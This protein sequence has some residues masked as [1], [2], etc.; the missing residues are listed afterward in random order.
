[1]TELIGTDWRPPVEVPGSLF[2]FYKN[3]DGM[4]FELDGEIFWRIRPIAELEKIA[5]MKS[6]ADPLVYA[7]STAFEQWTPEEQNALT[8]MS[9][10]EALYDD[11]LEFEVNPSPNK[12]L[13]FLDE[14]DGSCLCIELGQGFRIFRIEASGKARLLSETFEECIRGH[15]DSTRSIQHETADD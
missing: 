2:T 5:S 4:H 6:T 14:N 12:W 15:L 9:E 10:K 3:C 7:S 11:L 1:M 13:R 8:S